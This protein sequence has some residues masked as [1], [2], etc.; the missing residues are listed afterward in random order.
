MGG[1]GVDGCVFVC[2]VI[3]LYM[4]YPSVRHFEIKYRSVIVISC[5]IY[6]FITSRGFI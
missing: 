4:A 6:V 3:V 1:G 2:G 5:I